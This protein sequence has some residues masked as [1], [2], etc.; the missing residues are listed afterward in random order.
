[1]PFIT[2]P[3]RVGERRGLRN[4]IEVLLSVRFGADGLKLMPEINEVYEKEK[5]EAILE[6]LRT[7]ANPEEVRRV[8]ATVDGK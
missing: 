4:G 3:E 5:L 6:A 8:W 2:T 1:M 7:A